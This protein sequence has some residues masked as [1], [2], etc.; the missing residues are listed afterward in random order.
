MFAEQ[1]H[2]VAELRLPGRRTDRQA[3]EASIMLDRR[4]NR[5]RWFRITDQQ[6]KHRCVTVDKGAAD[7]WRAERARV[8]R[9]QC[10]AAY[11]EMVPQ[12]ASPKRPVH[13]GFGRN[14]LPVDGRPAAKVG[15]PRSSP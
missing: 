4:D 2:P 3:A 9:R 10:A 13:A 1:H 11:N 5:Y 7:R 12:N 6:K 15:R 8:E 14:G